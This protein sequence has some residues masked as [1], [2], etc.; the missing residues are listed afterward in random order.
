MSQITIEKLK[1]YI[2]YSGEFPVLDY[3]GDLRDKETQKKYKEKLEE[4]KKSGLTTSEYMKQKLG[5][6][7]NSDYKQI[8]VPSDYPYC[9][10]HF[11]LWINS[12]KHIEDLECYVRLIFNKVR[13]EMKKDIPEAIIFKNKEA[14]K[15]VDLTHFHIIY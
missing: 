3:D 15:S 8:I 4:I 10:N 12:G 5:F 1:E 11:I 9:E 6:G 13:R 2:D 14:N 7:D